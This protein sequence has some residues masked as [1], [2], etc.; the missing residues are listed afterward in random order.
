MKVRGSHKAWDR[1]FHDNSTSEQATKRLEEIREDYEDDVIQYVSECLAHGSSKEEVVKSLLAHDFDQAEAA[2]VV[3][4]M[5]E[6][7]KVARLS[8]ADDFMTRLQRKFPEMT[9]P[10]GAPQAILTVNGI[11]FR[12]YGSRDFDP[13]T[14]TYV[15]TVALSFAYIPLFAVSAFRVLD[16]EGGGWHFLGRVP[17]SPLAKAWSVG[18]GVVLT[19]LLFSIVLLAGHR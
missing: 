3:D 10:V 19:L 17:L 6:Y 8:T 9:P 5:A 12:A 7:R 18:I 16:A 2:R 1:P 11:G 13:E 14:K 4:R 15:K